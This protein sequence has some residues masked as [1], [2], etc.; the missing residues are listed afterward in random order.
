MK[1]IVTIFALAFSLSICNLTERLTNSNESAN[2]QN[3][4]MA[5]ANGPSRDSGAGAQEAPSSNGNNADSVPGGGAAA[6]GQLEG[7]AVSLPKPVYPPAARAVKA[8]GNVVVDVEVD[9]TGKVISAK[10]RSGHP[11][12]RA[13]AEQAA[14]QA[15][16][17][18]TLEE[19]K[20]VKA[21][22]TITY[23][24]QP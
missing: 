16:F 4:N 17:T 7:K 21:T 14:R 20:P 19:G 23:N 9:E 1:S 18:P 22:G 15:R 2:S 10:A 24:F 13:S 8:S 12:L 11:L 6:G 3:A 5:N